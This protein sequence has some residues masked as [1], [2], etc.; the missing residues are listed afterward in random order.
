MPAPGVGRFALL[1]QEIGYQFIPAGIYEAGG[2]LCLG[3][4]AAYEL[5]LPRGISADEK[6]ERAARQVMTNIAPLLPEALRG[7]FS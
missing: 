3:F 1:L 5:N 4:G 6:D 2:A 7:E